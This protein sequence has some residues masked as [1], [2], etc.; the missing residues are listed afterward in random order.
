[1][2][3]IDVVSVGARTPLGLNARQTGFMLRAGFPAAGEAPLADASGEPIAMALL[4]TLDGRLVGAARLAALARAPLAEAIA[5]VRQLAVEVYLSIDQGLP[6]SDAA[7][8]HLT[9]V[10]NDL[11]PGASVTVEPRGETGLVTFLQA[12]IESLELRRVDAVILG[13][14]HSDHDPRLIGALEAS[15]RLFARDNLDSRI[16]GE[17]AAF[18]VLM[19]TVEAAG[20]KLP[21]LAEVAGHGVG[22]E[23]ATPDN[24][25]PA[26]TAEG[27]SAAVRQATARLEQEGGAA[28][29]LW[30]D[31]TTEMRRLAEWQSVFVRAHRVLSRPYLV[32]SPAQRIGYLGAAALPLFVASAATAWAHGY[33][34]SPVALGIAGTDAGERAA[35]LLRQIRVERRPTRAEAER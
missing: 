11:L 23:A 29:W 7:V 8:A 32:D 27:M 10:V 33:G 21:R 20:K 17:A 16:P 19:R 1:M 15:G 12:A 13:G 2:S 5:P 14:V 4:P 9:A 34:P 25:A 31:L 6:D 30:T 26:I 18:V 28:G 3:G 35:L 24:D 22:R